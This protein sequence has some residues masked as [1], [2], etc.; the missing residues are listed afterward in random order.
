MIVVYLCRLCWRRSGCH[1]VTSS[2]IVVVLL[3][4]SMLRRSLQSSRSLSTV[5]G[6]SRSSSRPRFS[7]TNVTYLPSMITSIRV[8]LARS[9]VIVKRTESTCGKF[10]IC[11]S[12]KSRFR[13]HKVTDFSVPSHMLDPPHGTRFQRTYAPTKIVKF[14]GN[15][16]KVTFLP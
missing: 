5:S 1:S 14:L 10:C 9:L 11:L 3:P 16:S 12:K 6:S 4:A 15:S 2:P 13:Q 8:S 7:S